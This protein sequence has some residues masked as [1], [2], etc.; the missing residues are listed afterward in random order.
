MEA[1]NFY[2]DILEICRDCQRPFLFFA[3][4]Q[5]YWYE[6][7]KFHIDAQCTRCTE[8]RKDVQQERKIFAEYSQLVNQTSFTDEQ[9][10]TLTENSIALWNQGLIKNLNTINRIKN[11]AI[12]QIPETEAAVAI[13]ELT[14]LLKTKN[15]EQPL[16]EK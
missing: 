15:A 4:E 5:K 13:L 1:R 12:E 14:D 16:D 11:I 3:E 2:V 10:V 9:L 6:T 7:L 8:C